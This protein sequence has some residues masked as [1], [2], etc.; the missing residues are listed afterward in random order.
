MTGESGAPPPGDGRGSRIA[1]DALRNEAW[2]P[3]PLL[4]ADTLSAA[5]GMDLWLKREDCTPAGSFKLRGALTAMAHRA[6]TVGDGGVWVASAGNYGLAIALAGRRWRV[7]VTVVVPR[8]ATRSKVV[9]IAGCG[10][11]VVE[12]GR[13]FDAAK[14][15]A[16][17]RAAAAGAAF[18]EDG[19]VEE[20][21]WGAATIAA[22]L[23][24]DPEPWDA[25]LV[26]LGNG[27][28]AKGIATELASRRAT[29]DIVAVV[30]SG[31]PAM[32]RALAGAAPEDAATPVHTIADGL[33][34]RVPIPEITAELRSLVSRVWTVEER[35]LL[36]AVRTLMEC[37]QVAA[38][39]SAAVT[40]AAAAEHRAD[41]GGRRVAAIITGAHLPVRLWAAAAAATPLV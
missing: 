9:R 5:L 27:S 40:V 15:Y 17:E 2:L 32:A 8:G 36:P 14:A 22:E 35:Q 25:I 7:P 30:T 26:P 41:L 31:A 16:R 39:P 13:D 33:A 12:H 29:T 4:R 19:V 34:V 24:A 18:W 21:A 11:H 23:A 20:M 38:E 6:S 28:L 3:T 37:E 10:G 1:R